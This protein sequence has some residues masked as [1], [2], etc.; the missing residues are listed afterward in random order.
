MG[1]LPV[2]VGVVKC[3]FFVGAQRAI[4]DGIPFFITPS[5]VLV[6]PGNEEGV[7]PVEEP[8]VILEARPPPQEPEMAVTKAT[9]R[10]PILRTPLWLG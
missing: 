1:W 4:E 5:E 10:L 8:M 2:Y 7:I 3:A 9:R 6:S